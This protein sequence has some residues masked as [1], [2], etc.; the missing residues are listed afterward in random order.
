MLM[1]TTATGGSP[2]MEPSPFGG[3]IDEDP[4]PKLS[5]FEFFYYF[6]IMIEPRDWKYK[7][8]TLQIPTCRERV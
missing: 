2:S 5:L 4:E 3:W 8:Y 7:E 1:I 6:F